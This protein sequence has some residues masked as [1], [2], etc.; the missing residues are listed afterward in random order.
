M[1][2]LHIV[3][4]GEDMDI[5]GLRRLNFFAAGGAEGVS[6]LRARAGYEKV[7]PGFSHESRSD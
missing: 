4:A 7:A 6:D 5:A 3:A 2:R 1:R